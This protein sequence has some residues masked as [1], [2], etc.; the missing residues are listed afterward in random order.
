MKFEEDYI[1]RKLAGSL[2]EQLFEL[3]HFEIGCRVF[4]TG[5]EFL[6]PD[7]FNLANLKKRLHHKAVLEKDI[8]YF[9]ILEKKGGLHINK[10]KIISQERFQ[11]R[12]A[13]TTLAKSPDFTI[14][15]PLGIYYNLK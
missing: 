15:T 6:Y 13:G 14:I 9:S 8:E 1:D 4:R 11:K 5:H 3:L 10:N 2:A 12:K 7:L